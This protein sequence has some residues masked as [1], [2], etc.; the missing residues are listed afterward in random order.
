[1]RRGRWLARSGRPAVPSATDSRSQGR[2]E[3]H[4]PYR[5]K[6]H[7]EVDRAPERKPALE[8]AHLAAARQTLRQLTSRLSQDGRTEQDRKH[9]GREPPTDPERESGPRERHHADAADERED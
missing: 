4:C 3:H 8:R 9:D 6:E 5:R 7:G 2:L 1:M